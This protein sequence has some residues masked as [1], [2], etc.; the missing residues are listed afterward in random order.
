MVDSCMLIDIGFKGR[1]WT[2]EKK[3]SGGS[4]TRVRLDRALGSAEWSAQFPLA[5]LS[6][7]T[8]STSD[9]CPIYLELNGEPT[10]STSAHVFRYEVAWETHENLKGTIQSSWAGGALC[11]RA[12]EIK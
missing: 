7:L 3:V 2:F 10:N 12:D 1:F 9:H 4:Y 8:A 5:S 11:V 6:H